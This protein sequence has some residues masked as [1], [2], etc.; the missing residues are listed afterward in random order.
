MITA[1][2]CVAVAVS[3][4]GGVAAGAALSVWLLGLL[5]KPIVEGAAE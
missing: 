5:A 4:L 2:M 3:A 1:A